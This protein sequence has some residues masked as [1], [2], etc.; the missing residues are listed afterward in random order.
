MMKQAVIYFSRNGSARIAAQLIAEKTGADQVAL[1]PL[2][3]FRSFL[4]AGFSAI[5]QKAVPLSGDPWGTLEGTESLILVSP[6]WAGSINPVMRSFIERGNFAGKRIHLVTLQAD[7]GK[8]SEQKV[9]PLMKELVISR[10]GSVAGTL[11]VHGATPGKA[12]SRDHIAEQ[13]ASADFS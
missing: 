3:S 8:D 12:A 11:A 10:E 2:K 9:L 5:R 13:L 7:P 4:R 6:V 1:E